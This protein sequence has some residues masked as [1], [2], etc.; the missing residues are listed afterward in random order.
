VHAVAGDVT[1]ELV[2]RVRARTDLPVA[3]GIGVKDRASAAEVAGYADGVI[4]GSSVV[5]AAGEGD[6]AEAP[7]RVR[8][9]VAELRA[10][11]AE[12]WNASGGTTDERTVS[13]L[14]ELSEVP[15]VDTDT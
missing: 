5:R 11:V 6:P 12:R 4:V 14:A 13:A 1:Q 3:V 2:G 9:L 15:R 8:A 7:D 10:G